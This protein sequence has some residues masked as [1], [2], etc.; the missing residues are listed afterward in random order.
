[1]APQRALQIGGE[2]VCRHG[3]RPQHGWCGGPNN[4]LRHRRQRLERREDAIFVLNKVLCAGRFA[5]DAAGKDV[6]AVRDRG[7]ALPGCGRV[8]NVEHVCMWRGEKGERV[9]GFMVAG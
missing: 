4:F 3:E 7:V 9:L 5:P 2:V 6:A 8:H 1:M